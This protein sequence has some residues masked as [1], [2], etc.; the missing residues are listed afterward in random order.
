MS[1][2]WIEKRCP[3]CGALRDVQYR[4]ELVPAA[5]PVPT[6]WHVTERRG[7]WKYITRATGNAE[8]CECIPWEY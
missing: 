8:V 3:D 2:I 4:Q 7:S 1:V 5:L 6:G